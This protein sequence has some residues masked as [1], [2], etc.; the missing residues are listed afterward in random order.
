MAHS[1]QRGILIGRAHGKFIAVE[2]P[3]NDY[4][5]IYCA[6]QGRGSEERLEA[7]QY[8]G[9]GLHA[10]IFLNNSVLHAEGHPGEF[11]GCAGFDLLVYS[12][13]LRAGV[14]SVDF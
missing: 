12:R 13:S 10:V 3:N 5:L 6:L 9:R 2:A 14:I 8:L 11:T 4:I 1:P 7:V